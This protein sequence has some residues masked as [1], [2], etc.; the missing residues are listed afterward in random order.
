MSHFEQENRRTE[1]EE[2]GKKQEG[3]L[4]GPK[5]I[6]YNHETNARYHEKKSIRHWEV[7]K[8]RYHR[9]CPFE[10]KK[11]LKSLANQPYQT[12]HT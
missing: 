10:F 6:L 8:E 11:T 1:A 4:K 7:K 3:Q 5:W 9:Y 2:L 12:N